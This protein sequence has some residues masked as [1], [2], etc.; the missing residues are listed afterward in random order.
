M[1]GKAVKGCRVVLVSGITPA[2]AGKSPTHI[3]GENKL[4]D[5]PRVCG[6][7]LYRRCSESLYRGSPPR[8]RGKV[9][10]YT[11]DVSG[12][13]ITPAY[14]GKS[15]V[16]LY[17]TEPV[18]DHPRVCGEKSGL[19]E[20]HTPAEGS[21]PRMRGKDFEGSKKAGLKGITPAYAGKSA[22]R[23]TAG[24]RCRDHPR[25]C[26]EKKY[27][28]FSGSLVSGSPPRMRGKD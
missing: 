7:K 17:Y 2:Y 9:N 22:Y 12:G 11:V 3:P 16:K 14:A 4:K 8:M 18:R 6:E 1:R 20:L 24:R 23:T 25:V 15:G 5:H 28:D 10:A 19:F 27:P 21:P 26:G 13:G